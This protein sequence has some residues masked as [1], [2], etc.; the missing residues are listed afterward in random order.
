MCQS[1]VAQQKPLAP[2]CLRWLA[3]IIPGGFIKSIAQSRRA[4]GPR[5]LV[6]SNHSR[7]KQSCPPAASAPGAS[8]TAQ[9]FLS[10]RW[11]PRRTATGRW[12][13]WCT[14]PG[15]TDGRRFGQDTAG[16]L[17]VPELKGLAPLVKQAGSA[18]KGTRLPMLSGQRSKI[19]NCSDRGLNSRRPV[20]KLTSE[21][22]SY[23]RSPLLGKVTYMNTKTSRFL[24]AL[25]QPHNKGFPVRRRRFF[26]RT[27]LDRWSYQSNLASVARWEQPIGGKSGTPP[28]G[29]RPT[30]RSAQSQAVAEHGSSEHGP[31]AA[32]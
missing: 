22:L 13:G 10:P 3:L 9:F 17:T 2:P 23:G 8:T 30:T 4:I 12:H 27:D 5:A 20:S 11:M 26:G 28:K 16:T 15:Q 14:T 1:Q 24:D 25:R 18:V 19:G 32:T 21:Q 6:R 7:L 31:P 29:N